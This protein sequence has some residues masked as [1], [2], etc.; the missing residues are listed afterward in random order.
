MNIKLSRIKSSVIWW[1]KTSDHLSNYKVIFLTF[2]GKEILKVLKLHLYE[3]SMYLNAF[4]EKLFFEK[5]R[6][7]KRGLST[8]PI[9][10]KA[11]N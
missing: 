6:R 11:Q 10:A 1:I 8:T 3:K 2:S 4:F 7:K 9:F 5:K